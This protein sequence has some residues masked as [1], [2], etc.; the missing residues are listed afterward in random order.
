MAKKFKSKTVNFYHIEGTNKDK[1]SEILKQI[2]DTLSDTYSKLKTHQSKDIETI[3][4]KD[5]N[6]YIYSMD[7][8]YIDEQGEDYAWLISIS[9]LDPTRPINIGDLN[10][11]IESRNKTLDKTEKEG[12]V[13]DTQ[14]LYDPNTH[15]CAFARTL[16][17]LNRALFKTFLLRFCD[18]R[19]IELAI[20]PDEVAI[21]KLDKMKQTSSLTYTVAKVNN[22]SNLADENEDELKDLKY[23]SDLNA[24]QMTMVLKADSMDTKGVIKKA[25]MLFNNSENLG[26]KKLELEGI[27]DDGVFEPV[28]LVQHKL[29][30]HGKVEYDNTVTRK[31]MFNFL[32]VAYHK[33]YDF[34]RKQFK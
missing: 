31:N 7:K 23:A 15:I 3:S 16:G 34:C 26:I 21:N 20:I 4:I 9:R 13:V 17:G 29:V 12:E 14:F 28:D 32:E 18:V 5:N 6:Y 8:A 11:E 24:N 27:N 25:K 1:E 19:G 33:Y 22:I 30:Y 2:D 10:K